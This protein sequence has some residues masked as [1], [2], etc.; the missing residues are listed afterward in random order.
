MPV[1]TKAK[2]KAVIQLGKPWTVVLPDPDGTIDAADRALLAHVYP[3]AGAPV[4]PIPPIPPLPPVSDGGVIMRPRGARPWWRSYPLLPLPDWMQPVPQARIWANAEITFIITAAAYGYVKGEGKAEQIWEL[5]PWAVGFTFK[6]GRAEARLSYEVK[7]VVGMGEVRAKAEGVPVLWI[8]MA[9]LRRQEKQRQELIDAAEESMLLDLPLSVILGS[10]KQ[11]EVWPKEREGLDDD[12]ENDLSAVL[13]TALRRLRRLINRKEFASKEGPEDA[14]NDMPFWTTFRADMLR[15]FSPRMRGIMQAAFDRQMALGLAVNMD[16][17]NE[18]MLQ[19]T[20]TY[21]NAWWTEIEDTT[22]SGL[23]AAIL[24]WQ[25]TGLGDAGLPDLTSSI[26]PLFGRDR[27]KRI[28]TTEVTRLFD[29]GLRMADNSAGIEEQEWRTVRDSRVDDICAELDGQK[30]PTNSGPRP[31]QDTHV[32]C[33]CI[34][35]PVIDG[36]ARGR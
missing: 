32:N 30:F 6:A 1:D 14:L 8:G 34:R 7:T 11:A 9:E 29:E 2:R 23:R 4:P 18:E 26:E 10:E 17:V 36:R 25:E 19:F 3:I 15:T 33:R 21:T 12:L 28:A 16:F 22:R 20:R 24:S 27:A 13:A 31:V 5:S 35:V